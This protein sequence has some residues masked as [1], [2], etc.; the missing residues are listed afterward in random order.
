[1]AY[2]KHTWVNDEIITKEKLNNMENG[3]FNVV[4]IVICD[5]TF[6]SHTT[7]QIDAFSEYAHQESFDIT[8]I[9][10]IED[11][12]VGD[13]IGLLIPNSS[14]GGKSIYFGVISD[15]QERSLICEG[16]GC[17]HNGRQ[18]FP[19]EVGRPGKDA[20]IPKMNL[21]QDVAED[22]ITSLR[23]AFNQLLSELKTNGYMNQQ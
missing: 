14:T 6:D 21:I 3:I 19:G 20:V 11:Y 4:N 13:L 1:M 10:C 9:T 22:N 7:S 16:R 8:Q 23:T 18:G 5:T 2:A 12:K 17:I 15:I